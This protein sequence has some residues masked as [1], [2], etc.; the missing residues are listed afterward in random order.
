MLYGFIDGVAEYGCLRCY[1]HEPAP[2]PSEPKL[3]IDRGPATRKLRWPESETERAVK[4]GC[5]QMGWLRLV[6]SRRRKGAACPNCGTWVTPSGGDGC[7]KG[8]PDVFIRP[9][10][11][12]PLLWTACEIKGS[13]TR[14]SA[15]Q[16]ALAEEGAIVI[17]RSWPEAR[18]A[19]H[20]VL[21]ELA[22][23]T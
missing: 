3:P 13:D 2:R 14:P 10:Q 9:P 4:V 21:A 19:V 11:F 16:A 5:A 6:T 20:G 17:V 22:A 23:R 1:H 7:S 8:L 12:P 18:A 15:E